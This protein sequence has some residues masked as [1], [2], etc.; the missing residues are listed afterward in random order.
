MLDTR[1]RECNY[2]RLNGR[3][4]EEIQAEQ[5]HRIDVRFPDGESYL[6]VVERMRS[7]LAAVAAA[8]D[9]QRVLAIGHAANRWALQH[10]LEGRAL[11]ELVAAP[12]DWREGWT[13]TIGT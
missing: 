1:L 6:D 4:V 2:G 13:F 10:L 11:E 5:P 3:P 12:F 8:H 9:G 7:L